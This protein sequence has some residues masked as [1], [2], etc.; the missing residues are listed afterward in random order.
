MIED[1]IYTLQILKCKLSSDDLLNKSVGKAVP[2]S[3]P[4]LPPSLSLHFFLEIRTAN[5]LKRCEA[6][7]RVEG[8]A[9]HQASGSTGYPGQ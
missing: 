4:S 7:H 8:K 1:F 5:L 2:S 3:I 9:R 6:V